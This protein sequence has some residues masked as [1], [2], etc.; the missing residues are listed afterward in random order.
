V[1]LD[2]KEGGIVSHANSM[3]LELRQSLRVFF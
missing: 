3:F 1:F 2:E